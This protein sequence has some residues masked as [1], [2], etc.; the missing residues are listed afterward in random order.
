MSNKFENLTAW[1]IAKDLAV[2]CYKITKI[3]PKNDYALISQITRAAISISANIAEGCSRSSKKDFLRFLEIAIGSAFELET[4]L[5]LSH[6]IKYIDDKDFNRLIDRN[7]R[8]IKL[9]Y[10]FKR[11]LK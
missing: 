4:L 7:E 3:F 9:I 5:A 1:Q 6:E 10:G 2:D 8:V 11:S